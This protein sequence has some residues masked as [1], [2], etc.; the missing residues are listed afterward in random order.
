MSDHHEADPWLDDEFPLGDGVAELQGTVECPYCGESVDV[1]LDPGS[2]SSQ[3]YIEDCAVCC[4]PWLVTVEYHADGSAS[5]F[6][7]ASDDVDGFD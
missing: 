5:V 3:E 2:G 4:R 6:A 7:S 1:V